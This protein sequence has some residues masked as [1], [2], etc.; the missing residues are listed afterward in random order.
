LNRHGRGREGAKHW[1]QSNGT[2]STRGDCAHC[3]TP[4]F[5]I[6]VGNSNPCRS[7]RCDLGKGLWA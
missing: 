5:L 6:I 1:N 2:D 4:D 3:D 7:E